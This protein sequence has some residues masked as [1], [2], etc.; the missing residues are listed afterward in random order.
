MAACDTSCIARARTHAHE[1]FLCAGVHTA[2]LFLGR[3][4]AHALPRGQGFRVGS[5]GGLASRGDETFQR[6]LARADAF[7]QRCENLCAACM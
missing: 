6:F 4:G 1:S 3:G 7:V 5:G 2:R